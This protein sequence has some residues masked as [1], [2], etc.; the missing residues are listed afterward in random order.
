MIAAVIRSAR[1]RGRSIGICGQAPS[2]Y[3]EFARFP[4]EQRI[5][6][7]PLNPDALLK[8]AVVIAEAERTCAGSGIAHLS[9]APVRV[10]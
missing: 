7:I 4:V 3:P 1:T 9:P 8:T 10:P 2:D 6:S 5:D